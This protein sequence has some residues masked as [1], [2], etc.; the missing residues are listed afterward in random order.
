MVASKLRKTQKED[1]EKAPLIDY[2][3]KINDLL[4]A[5]AAKRK[6]YSII[7]LR[8]SSTQYNYSSRSSDLVPKANDFKLF[9]E[10]IIS[11]LPK[12]FSDLRYLLWSV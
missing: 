2:T 8:A 5:L 1:D 7:Y 9:F 10:N 11:E 3:Q 12:R 4:E 6:Y